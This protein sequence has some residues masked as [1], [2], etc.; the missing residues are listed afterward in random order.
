VRGHVDPNSVVGDTLLWKNAQKNHT[1]NRISDTINRIIPHRSPF[2]TLFVC[3][4]LYVPS[5]VTSRHHWIM[6]NTVIIVPIPGRLSS[7]FL[8]Y[9]ISPIY[10]VI[11]PMAAVSG[12]GLL[13]TL[14][15]GWFSCIHSN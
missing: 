13:F 9:L 10:I 3:N 2:V 5:R 14:W 1:K 4:P 7:Y 15:N 6:V 12:H 11:A 8:N